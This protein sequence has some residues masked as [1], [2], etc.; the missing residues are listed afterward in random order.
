MIVRIKVKTSASRADAFLE[1]EC[2]LVV[3]VKA[4]PVEGKANA[5]IIAY[6]S[7]L[8]KVPKSSLA[9]TGGETSRFKKLQVGTEAE[10]A[11]HLFLHDLHKK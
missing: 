8:L 3:Q 2:V 11:F 9:I 10:A 7:K 1:A 5:A 6:L 4:A